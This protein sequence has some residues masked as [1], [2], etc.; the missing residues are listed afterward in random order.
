MAKK[1][2]DIEYDYDFQLIGISSHI[3]DYRLC[4]AINSA[5]IG[6][7]FIK[8][9]DFKISLKN[10]TENNFYSQYVY[11]NEDAGLEFILISNRGTKNYL[12]PEIKQADFVLI[13]K[14][15]FAEKQTEELI[16]KLKTIP[17]VLTAFT[18]EASELK[19]KQNLIF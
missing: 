17:F 19:S 1:T 11:N 6:I 18:I 14:G 10:E 15:N 7:N 16:K 8:T 9:E 12:L 4:W 5:S 3:K 13:I 2:L